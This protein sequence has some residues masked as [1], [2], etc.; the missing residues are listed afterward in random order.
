MKSINK[1]FAFTLER[2]ENGPEIW[3]EIEGEKPSSAN[4]YSG[5]IY[6][7]SARDSK[8]GVDLTDTLST[9]EIEWIIERAQK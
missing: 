7:E 1:S 5:E 2:D 4:G 9:D 8:T 6:I 3:V